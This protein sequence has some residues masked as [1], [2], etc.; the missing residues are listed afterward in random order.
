MNKI[1]QLHT[2]YYYAS[3]S[4]NL[5]CR[6]CWIEPDFGAN[7]PAA[8]T[9]FAVLEP[10][11]VEAIKLGLRNV[12]LTGG[13]PF[14]H[15]EID[16]II[17]NL[18]KKGLGV[19]IETNGTLLNR[20]RVAV[21][22]QHKVS[23]AVSLD[24]AT[25]ETH[26]NLR[27]VD[28]CYD[29]LLRN[30]ALMQ[31]AGMRY[32]VIFSLHKQNARELADAIR[33]VIAK[34][35]AS[36]KINPINDLGRADEM[37]SASEL[38]SVAE[39]LDFY[40]GEFAQIVKDCPIP[41]YFD[42]PPALKSLSDLRRNN[43]GVCGII[44]IL[45][46]LHDGSAGLCGIGEKIPEMNFGSV[47]DGGLEKIW[48]ENSFLQQI[49][50]SFPGNLRGV[51]SRCRMKMHCGGKCMAH[52]FVATGSLVEGF[53]FCEEALRLGLFPKTRLNK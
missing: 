47:L 14:L 36:F 19:T 42:I 6:H 26:E 50:E 28:G 30:M 33:L 39:T 13:E 22:A 35:A 8:F 40:N 27:A 15:P 18:I 24:G 3:G 17:E 48:T 20:E 2:I 10:V 9:P 52:T 11:F 7:V 4:C 23:I 12:K 45:G 29:M 46:L 5:R 53:P 51:C 32:Q 31:E 16:A 1:P 21:L 49:R 37:K 41:V 43:M 44:G 25:R 38:F 34:G